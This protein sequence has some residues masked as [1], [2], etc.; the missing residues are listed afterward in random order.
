MTARRHSLLL[1]IMVVRMCSSLCL[2]QS[3]RCEWAWGKTKPL[4]L[5][6]PDKRIKFRDLLSEE[7]TRQQPAVQIMG[8]VGE[9]WLPKGSRS[10]QCLDHLANQN[11]GGRDTNGKEM[12]A[13]TRMILT[14][15]LRQNGRPCSRFCCQKVVR[16]RRAI[17]HGDEG[18]ITKTSVG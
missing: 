1:C 2:I 15:L 4:V 8:F 13:A 16:T 18:R 6:P 17:R 10:G 9:R 3:G 7:A 5:N 11:R 14:L 12:E